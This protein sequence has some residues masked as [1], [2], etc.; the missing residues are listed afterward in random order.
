MTA[1]EGFNRT[2]LMTSPELG[3]EMTVATQEFPPSSD[4]TSEAIAE[5]RVAYAQ[6][7]ETPDTMPRLT[8]ATA[9]RARGADQPLGDELM[10]LL[11]KLGERLAFEHAGARLYEALLSKHRAYGE[12]QGGPSAED[13]A[14]ILSEE[15]EHADFLERA[16]TGLGGDPTVLTPS[17][18]LAAN[19]SM[20]LPQVLSDPRTNLLQCLE[21][22]VVAELADNECWATLNQ[23]A[24]QAGHDELGEACQLAI[25]H[26][27]D[28]LRKVRAWI[29]TGQGRV[30]GDAGAG[31]PDDPDARPDEGDT[32]EDT[33]TENS[34][35]DREGHAVSEEEKHRG[36]DRPKSGKAGSRRSGRSER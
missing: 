2:G 30:A 11:D 12:F 23:L 20:G 17:A 29:A 16:I 31:M 35:V 6:Q 10:R 28:H 7:S 15:Y 14:H 5:V 21:A 34:A 18:N 3:Q 4:G 22:I 32:D 26:E 25:E 33:F 13:L 36:D 19:M 27:R 24:R 1:H 8:S 9:G